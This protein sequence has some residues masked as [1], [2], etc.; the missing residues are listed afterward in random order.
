MKRKIFRIICIVIVI[1]CLAYLGFSLYKTYKAQKDYEELRKLKEQVV[2]NTPTPILTPTPS[3]SP[4]P[5]PSAT[6]SAS[7]TPTN[8]PTPTEMVMLPEYEALYNKNKDFVGWIKFDDTVIDY[9][10]MHVPNEGSNYYY[11]RRNF[12]KKGSTAGSIFVD[13][14]CKPIVD[15]SQNVIIYGHNLR[16]GT[17]FTP[18]H[19]LKTQSFY[20]GHKI[21][22][23]DTLYAKEYYEV[24]SVFLTPI[25][26]S[27]D[28]VF[29][30]YNFIDAKNEAEYKEFADY[31]KSK[32]L[33]KTDVNLQFGD[34]TITLMTCTGKDKERLV[35]VARKIKSTD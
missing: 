17:M 26:S 33:I 10:V 11:L 23:F 25:Y 35:V 24:A 21:I 28:K 34:E 4:E 1:G 12:D 5:T 27:T 15:R 30:V 2:T 16:A 9:P 13:G 32:S 19:K 31:V 14:R 6:P 29:K 8:S 18:L 22:E 20:D 3:P 7:P